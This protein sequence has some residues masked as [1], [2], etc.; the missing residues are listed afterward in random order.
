MKRMAEN[1]MRMVDAWNDDNLNL[2]TKVTK[3]LWGRNEGKSIFLRYCT[4][5]KGNK[6]DPPNSNKEVNL[7]K[8]YNV[9]KV[10]H[11][12]CQSYW[13]TMQIWQPNKWVTELRH[14]KGTEVTTINPV[15]N[16][17]NF[18][19]KQAVTCAILE[20]VCEKSKY[21]Q[22]WNYL[23]LNVNET[24]LAFLVCIRGGGAV[25]FSNA[26]LHSEH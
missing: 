22:L 24:M 14:T 17:T 10:D 5:R 26:C 19:P 7:R 23:P 9:G 21:G 12:V 15:L 13:K 16:T 20:I 11:I 2:E 25:P 18:F 8:C 1:C 6:Q 4:G 3:S